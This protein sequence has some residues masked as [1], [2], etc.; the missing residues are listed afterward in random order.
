MAFDKPKGHGDTSITDGLVKLML[1]QDSEIEVWSRFVW[2]LW[3]ELNPLAM[4]C[5]W[6]DA[7]AWYKEKYVS[8]HQSPSL[9]INALIKSGPDIAHAVKVSS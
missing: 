3:Y 6:M 5:L 2:N 1:N 7:W 8:P 4:F 9:F